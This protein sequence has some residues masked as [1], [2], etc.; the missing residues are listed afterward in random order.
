MRHATILECGKVEMKLLS[1]HNGRVP[2]I[3]NVP[4]NPHIFYTCGE[5]GLVQHVSH[6]RRVPFVS[7]FIQNYNMFILFFSLI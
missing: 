6:D 1:R 7:K 5:D 4:E 3:A 2:K